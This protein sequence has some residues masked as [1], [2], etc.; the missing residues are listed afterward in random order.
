MN[1]KIKRTGGQCLKDQVIVLSLRMKENI[2]PSKNAH[3]IL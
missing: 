1:T 2:K 3:K